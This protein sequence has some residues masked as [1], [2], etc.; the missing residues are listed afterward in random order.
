MLLGT[1]HNKGQV[2]RKAVEMGLRPAVLILWLGFVFCVQNVLHAQEA[3][4][5]YDVLAG[6]DDKSVWQAGIYLE[7]ITNLAHTDKPQVYT[8]FTATDYDQQTLQALLEGRAAFGIL[9][10]SSLWQDDDSLALVQSRLRIVGV[11]WREVLHILIRSKYVQSGTVSD[12]RALSKEQ[13]LSGSTGTP[14]QILKSQV[15]EP[16]K[17]Q[18]KMQAASFGVPRKDLNQ[19]DG[20]IWL[21]G[22]PSA[23]MR[24][25]T[26]M[27]GDWNFLG[28]SPSHTLQIE[29]P[30]WQMKEIAKD[31]YHDRGKELEMLSN[32]VYLVGLST[33]DRD[34]VYHVLQALY[35]DCHHLI[36]QSP[37][38]LGDMRGQQLTELQSNPIAF[39][40]GALLFYQDLLEGKLPAGCKK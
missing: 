23:F 25:L 33:L 40:E 24:K 7:T 11:L 34:S 12:L 19:V 21:S 27:G 8:H 20:I 37:I 17:L 28:L 29:N 9:K 18:E 13:I 36:A 6:R 22:L 35:A 14:M 4:T 5:A 30:A 32:G 39:H 10:G 3:H 2:A 16:L 38:N 31:I 15:L 1:V 26:A